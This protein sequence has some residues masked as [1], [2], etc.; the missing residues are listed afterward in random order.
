MSLNGQPVV[1]ILFAYLL[2]VG[3]EAANLM[4]EPEVCLA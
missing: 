4:S 3:L 1:K 2:A